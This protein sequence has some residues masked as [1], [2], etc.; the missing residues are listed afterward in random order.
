MQGDSS[1]DDQHSLKCGLDLIGAGLFATEKRDTV[2]IWWTLL[3]F[4]KAFFIN[5][6]N[7]LCGFIINVVF[8]LLQNRTPTYITETNENHITRSFVFSGCI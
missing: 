1:S 2:C 4:Q 5:S 6:Q 8:C 7:V 3:K